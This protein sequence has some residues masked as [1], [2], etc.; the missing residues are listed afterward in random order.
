MY[1]SKYLCVCV[2]HKLWNLIARAIF[3]DSFWPFLSTRQMKVFQGASH[4]DELYDESQLLGFVDEVGRVGLCL[5]PDVFRSWKWIEAFE[6][7]KGIHGKTDCSK[8][9]RTAIIIRRA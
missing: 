7:T 6:V 9:Q 1:I 4:V 5:M 8:V 2:M 3:P